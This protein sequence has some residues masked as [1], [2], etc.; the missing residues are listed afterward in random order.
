[1]N[2]LCA[3]TQFPYIFTKE[4]T[5]ILQKCCIQGLILQLATRIVFVIGKAHTGLQLR[6]K[7]APAE[8]SLWLTQKFD[9]HAGLPGLKSLGGLRLSHQICKAGHLQKVGVEVGGWDHFLIRSQIE[10]WNW[11]HLQTRVYLFYCIVAACGTGC[12]AKHRGLV[13]FIPTL[14]NCMLWDWVQWITG[15]KCAY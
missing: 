14:L 5:S 6:K 15:T 10:V 9:W 8:I 12:T 11:Q 13:L 4:A 1:M 2:M 7:G 3:Q